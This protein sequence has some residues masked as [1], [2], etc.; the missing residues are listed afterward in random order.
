MHSPLNRNIGV[1]IFSP[2]GTNR[3]NVLRRYT[4]NSNVGQHL[5]FLFSFAMIFLQI[6]IMQHSPGIYVPGSMQHALWWFV[7]EKQSLTGNWRRL[8]W[9]GRS[10]GI[11]GN[12]TPPRP[13]P[14]KIVAS[15]RIDCRHVIWSLVPLQ[16]FGCCK[17]RINIIDVP[18]SNHNN[19]IYKFFFFF[20]ITRKLYYI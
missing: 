6:K 1:T 11:T 16:S 12:K 2:T 19:K 13:L 7:F 9:N 18:M 20:F 8:N 4:Y 10:E 15:I 3:P 14:V 17:S 5:L